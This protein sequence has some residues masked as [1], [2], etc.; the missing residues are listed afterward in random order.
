[1]DTVLLKRLPWSTI[2]PVTGTERPDEQQKAI[3]SSKPEGGLND[4]MAAMVMMVVAIALIVVVIV[5]L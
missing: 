1:M 5:L 3:R 4:G 2:K